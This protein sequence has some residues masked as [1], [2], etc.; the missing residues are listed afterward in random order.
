M[1]M[2]AEAAM[3][4]RERV[5]L[6]RGL[7]GARLDRTI[8]TL[9]AEL[10]P[11][12]RHWAGALCASNG[13]RA[14]S[15]LDDVHNV[16]RIELAAVLRALI[17]TTQPPEID[18]ILG[19]LRRIAG[20]AAYGYFH[21]VVFTGL[22]GGSGPARRAGTIHTVRRELAM[23]L[24]RP[25]S[26]L[27]VVDEANRRARTNRRDPGKQ[28]TLVTLADVSATH[29]VSLDGLL[30][31]E[32]SAL[33]FGAAGESTAAA[34]DR[35]D[36]ERLVARVLDVC[37]SVAAPLGAAARVWI[38]EAL[39]EPPVIG[40]AEEIARCLAVDPGDAAEL[41]SGCRTVAS[42]ICHTEFGISSPFG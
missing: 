3:Q 14:R 13:D 39:A 32:A 19:Y 28:G 27:E 29:P 8:S 40:T 5:E 9:L 24:G 2:D 36:A 34:L 22:G 6:H 4:F 31:V 42:L 16:I 21:S 33:A 10:E 20:R 23:D 35:V 25:P 37:A 7:D 17:E 41:L 15:H 1:S 11:D 26:D 18:N 38:G 12:T 30:D